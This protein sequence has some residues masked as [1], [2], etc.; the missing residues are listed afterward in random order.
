MEVL[1]ESGIGL[2]GSGGVFLGK[3]HKV[4]AVRQDVTLGGLSASSIRHP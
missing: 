4:G 2:C 3:I 1:E